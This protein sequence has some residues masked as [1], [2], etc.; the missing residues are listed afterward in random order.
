MYKQNESAVEKPQRCLNIQRAMSISNNQMNDNANLIYKNTEPTTS[1]LTD[2][3]TST[4]I[5]ADIDSMRREVRSILANADLVSTT[6]PSIVA[7]DLSDE[8]LLFVIQYK[9]YI[10]NDFKG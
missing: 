3:R 5:F 9:S 7:Q 4:K 6:N 2:Y 1:Q 10:E 8:K